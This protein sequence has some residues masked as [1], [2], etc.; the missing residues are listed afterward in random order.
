MSIAAG[1]VLQRAGTLE[2]TTER[3][4]AALREGN[5]DPTAFRVTSPYRVIE[6]GPASSR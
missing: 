6:I 2:A 3:A 4:L 5:E 1:P